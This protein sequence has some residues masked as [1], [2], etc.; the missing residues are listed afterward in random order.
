[1]GRPWCYVLLSRPGLELKICTRQDENKSE[2]GAIVKATWLTTRTV[3]LKPPSLIKR[4]PEEI[5]LRLLGE[6]SGTMLFKDSQRQI[7]IADLETGVMEQFEL[8]D[9]FDGL[10]RQKVVLLE[11]DWLALFVS[12]LGKW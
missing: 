7:Y 5:Y 3:E 2:D 10:N 1:M 6:K 9:G 4:K 12:R 11:M 8:P